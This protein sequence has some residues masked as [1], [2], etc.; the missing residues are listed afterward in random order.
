MAA[1]LADRAAGLPGVEHLKVRINRRRVRIA[2]VGPAD[3]ASVQRQLRAELAAV[4]LAGPLRLDVRTAGRGRRA[5]AGPVEEEPVGE[6]SVVEGSVPE[7][8]VPEGPVRG[9]GGG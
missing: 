6:D 9:G 4:T 1:L 2:L 3:P 8:S 7:R 5:G